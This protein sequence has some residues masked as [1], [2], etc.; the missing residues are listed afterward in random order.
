MKLLKRIEVRLLLALL[1]VGLGVLVYKKWGGRSFGTQPGDAPFQVTKVELRRDHG[2]GVL[3]LTIDF[4]NREGTQD[5]ATGSNEATENVARLVTGAGR[6]PDLFF[7][8]GD[9]PPVF[10][11]GERSTGTVKYWIERADLES[12][13]YFEA[14]GKRAAVKSDSAFDLN[15]IEDQQSRTFT[16]PDWN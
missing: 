3:S 10:K 6:S 8:A 7:L 13:L 9:F 5:I 15:R 16:E 1:I 11:A 14:G 2:F 4:D 12:A